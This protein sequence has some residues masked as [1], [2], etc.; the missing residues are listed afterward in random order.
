[1]TPLAWLDALRQDLR[2]ATRNL[3]R[4]PAFTA[5]ATLSL[6][7]G[8][9]AN[10]AIFALIYSVLL[11]PLPVSHPEQLVEVVH[12]GPDLPNDIF[13]YHD[14]QSLRQA[15]GFAQV[16]AFGGA[17]N[18]EAVHGSEPRSV[19]VTAVAGN[20]FATIG[21]LPLQGRLIDAEDE[22]VRAPVVVISADLWTALF[23]R[24]PDAIGATITLQGRGFTVIGVTPGSYQGLGYPGSFEAAIPLSTLSLVGGDSAETAG[25]NAPTLQIVGR[26]AGRGAAP[27]AAAMIDATF[28]SCCARESIGAGVRGMP[29]AASIHLVNIEHGIASFKFDVAAM[30]SRLLLE[31]MGGAVVVLLAAC[32]NIATLLL[33]RALAREREL[34]IRLSLGASRRRLAGQMLVESA[35]LA[36][37]GAMAG[38]MLA[39][40]ALRVIAHHMPGP[41]ADRVGLQLNGEILGFTAAVAVGSVLLFGLVPAWRATRT[42][43]IA[44][45][46]VAA[47][48]S[49]ARRTGMLDLG[50]VVAQVAIALVLVNAAGLFV[51]TLRNLRT[52]NGGFAVER[53][54]TTRLDSRG[55]PYENDGIIAVADPLLREA[56]RIPGVRSAAFS[57]VVPMFGGRRI[58]SAIAVEGYSP[59]PDQDLTGWINPVTPG[60]FATLGIALRQGRDFSSDDRAA[61]QRV[62]I[63]NDAFVH[64][65]IR[66][67]DPLGMTVRS[68]MGAD[69][70]LMAIVGVARDARY[71]DL[72]QPALP[73]IYMPLAQ[74][75]ALPVVGRLRVLN[76]TVRTIADDA[77]IITSLRNAVRAEAPD[78]RAD[79][80]ETIE[81]S[82][83]AAMS[84]ETLT[85]ELASLF[86]AVALILAAIGLYGLV[87]YHVAQRTREIGVRM[88][89]GSGR[90]SVVWMVLRQAL[91]LVT[92]G[93]L[94]GVPLAFGGG[95]VIAAE[96]FG[97]AG[98]NQFFV[99]G[100]ALLLLAAAVVASALPAQRAAKVDP[101]IALRAD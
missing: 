44:P 53:T 56:A 71:T 19:S 49:A 12:T 27:R 1:M 3:L 29:A 98:Q 28:R 18:V 77:A 55:T 47:S 22:R 14:F 68:I 32:A 16:T 46:K 23:N 92:I 67:R 85:A 74:F 57:M 73:M 58:G 81:A 79:G 89:L 25:A 61:D 93:V 101:V 99:L 96:L 4:A 24:T 97:L 94:V 78:L 40:L 90:S 88:A 42:A 63:V 31:L 5:V 21:I 69:T 30:F 35:L 52:V 10:S 48:S 34:A 39:G 72:R 9:G 17:G 100:A 2:Y 91:G 75:E 95:K 80:P 70:M 65:Y 45:L 84:R 37:I 6:A 86:G 15:S 20:F 62:A 59:S 7:I 43:L 64:Q 83:D 51:A 82:L 33:A 50:V 36:S 26:V 11:L 13:S 76:L 38:L 8:I 60:F 87:S 66:D 41:I 54:V